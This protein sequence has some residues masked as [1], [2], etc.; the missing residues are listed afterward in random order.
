MIEMSFTSKSGTKEQFLFQFVQKFNND[1]QSEILRWIL[2]NLRNSHLS[3][4][5]SPSTPPPF[6]SQCQLS[7]SSVSRLRVGQQ[8]PMLCSDWLILISQYSLN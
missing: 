5:I 1:V 6:M 7:D 4:F 8:Y 2:I 3:V